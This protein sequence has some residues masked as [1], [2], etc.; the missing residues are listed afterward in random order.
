MKTQ[1]GS[2]LLLVIIVFAV[3]FALVGISLEQSGDVLV[4]IRDHHLETV[5]LNL[6]EAGIEYAIHKIIHS[7]G[8]FYGE[9][10]GSLEPTGTFYISVS[11][12]TPSDKVEIISVGTAKVSGSSPVV[13]KSLRV[14]VQLSPEET[15]RPVILLSRE[16]VS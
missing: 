9:E 10:K 5:S 8:D 12:L 3:L 16:D 7:E 15:E 6:A 1:R 2:A 14:V 4:N 11:Q 13:T